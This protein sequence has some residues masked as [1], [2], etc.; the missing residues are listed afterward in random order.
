MSVAKVSEISA[1][2]SKSFEDAVQQDL[3]RAG[4]TLRHIRGAWIK[5]QHV[6]CEEGRIKE[7]AKPRRKRLL[8]VE[9]DRIEQKSIAELLGHDDIEIVAA[10]TG[11]EAKSG[12]KVTVNYGARRV[13]GDLSLAVAPGAFVAM[14]V[15]REE[16]DG[17]R[18]VLYVLRREVNAKRRAGKRPPFVPGR[19]R[20]R[21]LAPD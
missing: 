17:E 8:V 11:A 16:N 9:D 12:D 6:H 10:G 15:Q 20:E 19:A 21:V 5:E 7:Y 13:W 4:K 14:D 1:T 18:R 2:S 3:A